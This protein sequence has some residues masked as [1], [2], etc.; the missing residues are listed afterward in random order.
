MLATAVGDGLI[1]SNPAANVRIAIAPPASYDDEAAAKALTDEELARLLAQVAPGWRP[2]VH[3]IAQTGV[4]I[5]EALAIRWGDLD[6]GQ[7]R[8]HVRRRARFGRVGPPKSRYGRRSIP[9]GDELA[10]DLWSRRKAAERAQDADL[11][12]ASTTGGFLHPANLH[13]RMLKP[14][15]RAAGVPWCGFH[16]LRHTCATTLFRRGLNAKQV[17]LWLGHSSPGF[18]IAAYVHLL[19]DDLPQVDVVGPDGNRVGKRRAETG[20]ESGMPVEA[21]TA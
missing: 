13:A 1:R 17:Q 6:V 5:S 21:E 15:A 2:L 7:R 14:A 12:V 10:R 3:L 19:P 11:V 16:T 18:T 9:L 4:R 8:P 20:R